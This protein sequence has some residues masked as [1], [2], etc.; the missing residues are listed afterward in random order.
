MSDVGTA[1][2]QG[3]ILRATARLIARQGFAETNLRQIAR[4]AGMSS[5]TL[6][7]YFPSKGEL[8]DALVLNAVLPLYH[9]SCEILQR[10]AHPRE[11][12][13]ELVEMTFELFDANW[14]MYH[15]ALQLGDHLRARKPAEFPSAMKALEEWVRRGQEAGLVRQGDA[16]VLA[17]LCQGM[18][19]RVQ[20]A[21]VFGELKPPLGRFAEEVVESCWRVLEP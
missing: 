15:V 4:E 20:R 9:K 2:R 19:L 6:H 11:V 18:I 5:G 1:Q 14:D 16:L 12:L 8:L 7:Y 13:A 3:G 21:R 17:M 10:E